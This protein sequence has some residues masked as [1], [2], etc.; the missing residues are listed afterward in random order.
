[1]TSSENPTSRPGSSSSARPAASAAASPSAS[2]SGAT[3]SPSSPAARTGWTTAAEEAGPD[4]VA[5]ACD[6][7]DATSCGRHRRGRH[8]AR[9]HRRPRLRSRHRPPREDGERRPGRVGRR[10]RHQRHRRRRSPPPPPSP[11]STS[12]TGVRRVPVV[13]ERLADRPVARPRLLRR[14]QGGAR[15]DGRGVALPSTPT[16]GS[17]G[18]SSATAAAARAPSTSGSPRLGRGRGRRRGRPNGSTRNLIA[19]ALVDVEELIRA[20]GL[21][22]LPAAPAASIESITVASPAPPDQTPTVRVSLGRG[23]ADH[24]VLHERRHQVPVASNTSARP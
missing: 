22:H 20:V 7:T 23:G 12:R 16:W 4:A 11:T 5:I 10:V 3:G 8:H 13:G 2:A 15:Q 9:R 21:V 6:V 14:E 18:S 1:M 24:A 17:P 19:G